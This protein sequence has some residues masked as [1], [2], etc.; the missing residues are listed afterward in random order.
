MYKVISWAEAQSTTF[1][2]RGRMFLPNEGTA[3]QNKF[4]NESHILPVL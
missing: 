4:I 2:A 1:Y 3:V